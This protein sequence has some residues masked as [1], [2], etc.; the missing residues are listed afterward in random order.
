M[1]LRS[2]LRRE[3]GEG[4]S[5]HGGS[6]CRRG[7]HL[8]R[9]KEMGLAQLFKFFKKRPAAPALIVITVTVVLCHRWV[10][11]PLEPGSERVVLVVL[12]TN[13]NTSELL[14]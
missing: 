2:M 1:Q 9:E 4:N 12:P 13:S 3:G 14:D 7:S 5:N 11:F 10:S 8:R 6:D